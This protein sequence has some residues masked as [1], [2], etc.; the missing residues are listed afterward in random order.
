MRDRAQPVREVFPPERV[1]FDSTGN[2]WSHVRAY[3]RFDGREYS[4]WAYDRNLDEFGS[5]KPC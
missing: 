4:G 5:T 2:T 3:N 1:R